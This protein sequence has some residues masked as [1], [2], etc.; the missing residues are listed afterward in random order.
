MG[1]DYPGKKTEADDALAIVMLEAFVIH[2]GD[3]PVEDS[4]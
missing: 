2:Q 1:T 4:S 3:L